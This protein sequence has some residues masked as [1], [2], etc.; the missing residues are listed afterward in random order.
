VRVDSRGA[1]H[2]QCG[3]RVRRV[4]KP[5]VARDRYGREHDNDHTNNTNNTHH[6]DNADN[7]DTTHHTGADGAHVRE[8]HRADHVG[9][10]HRVPWPDA[11]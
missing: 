7:A 10:L 9:R 5:N 2:D 8:R 3:L 6:T 11:A 1:R 4:D